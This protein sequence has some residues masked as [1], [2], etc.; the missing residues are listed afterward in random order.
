MSKPLQEAILEALRLMVLSIIP[1]TIAGLE[2][3]TVN[4]Q[5]I[6]VTAAITLLR[7]TDKLLHSIG[8]ERGDE[9]LSKGLVQ[10]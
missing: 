5:L 10:F 4:L 6:G 3:G 9:R 2:T 1:I 8:K 7:F